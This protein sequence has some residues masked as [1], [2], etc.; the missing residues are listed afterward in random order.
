M[1]TSRLALIPK[2]RKDLKSELGNFPEENLD[3]CK[4]ILLDIYEPRE[5]YLAV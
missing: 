5:A 1:G 4:D 3:Q 2:T